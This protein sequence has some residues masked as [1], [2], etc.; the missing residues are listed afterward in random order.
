M[1][2]WHGEPGRHALAARGIHTAP[3]EIKTNWTDDQDMRELEYQLAQ[4]ANDYIRERYED[5]LQAKEWNQ[6]PDDE[7]FRWWVLSYVDIS[8]DVSIAEAVDPIYKRGRC[9]RCVYKMAKNAF[10]NEL[11]RTGLFT[12]EEIVDM[13]KKW[14]WGYTSV[15]EP[16]TVS[17]MEV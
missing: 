15:T 1:K 3:S 14:N 8:G 9:Q 16:G 6:I 7:E 12:H 11:I 13:D 10:L 2:G 4:V 5:F 17:I